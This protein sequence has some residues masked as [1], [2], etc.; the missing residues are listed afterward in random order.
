[1]LTRTRSVN[2]WVTVTVLVVVTSFVTLSGDTVF[3]VVLVTVA[4]GDGGAPNN[5]LQTDVTAGAPLN[6]D[7]TDCAISHGFATAA[8]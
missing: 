3:V 1:M 6:L 4:V 8:P 7:R 2:F 5:E